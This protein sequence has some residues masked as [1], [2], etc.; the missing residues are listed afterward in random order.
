MRNARSIVPLG[1]KALGV[2][3]AGGICCSGWGCH[4]HHY[5]YY[6]AQGVGACPPGTVVP[7]TVAGPVCDIPSTVDGGTPVVGSRSTIIENGR[8]SRVVV[9]E[10]NSSSRS[11]KFG[12]RSADL[13]D[14]PAM[15]RV[16]G[17][18]DDPVVK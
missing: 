12:W 6:G 18:L 13:D 14:A 5:Y 11:A 4:Q 3:V 10:P 17:A 2:V 15:T 16:E 1:R 8:R 7:S 9:S